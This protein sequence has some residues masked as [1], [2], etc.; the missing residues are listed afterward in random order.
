V[1]YLE[2]V[3]DP[4][5]A[6]AAAML[7]TENGH[8]AQWDGRARRSGSQTGKSE[9]GDS[10]ARSLSYESYRALLEGVQFARATRRVRQILHD[11]L[12]ASPVT[13]LWPVEWSAAGIVEAR[14]P[15]SGAVREY[16][17][18]VSDGSSPAE[19][20]V[21]RALDIGELATDRKASSRRMAEVGADWAASGVF[22]NRLQ[23]IKR[24]FRPVRDRTPGVKMSRYVI[25]PYTFRQQFIANCRQTYK[26]VEI[27]ALIGHNDVATMV[28]LTAQR[29]AT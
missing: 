23:H 10:A 19:H 11:F 7:E 9:E 27:A 24:Q 2:G 3:N 13:G 26:P 20:V 28:D 14:S 12:E 1:Y 8:L 16:L 29:G 18:V 22:D 15:D 4:D 17:Q 5:A 25:T 6:E 21:L